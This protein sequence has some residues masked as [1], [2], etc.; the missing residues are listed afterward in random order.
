MS[1]KLK[2]CFD[3]VLG[4]IPVNKDLAKKIYDY[5]TWIIV[6]SKEMME[7]YGGNL[8][9]THR[10]WF[11]DSLITRLYD[12]FE[13]DEDL[14]TPHVRKVTTINHSFKV[15]AD[16]TN[17]MLMYWIHRFLEDTKLDEK[18]R[19]SAIYDLS[20]IFFY[21]C[22]CIIISDQFVF[23]ADPHV[24]RRTYEN[25]SGRYLIKKLGSWNKVI[26]YRAKALIDKKTSLHRKYLLT[27]KD[28]DKTVYAINDSQGRIKGT[29]KE[30]YA[31][32]VI[33]NQAG[34]AISSMGAV[35]EDMEGEDALRERRG[36][37][38]SVVAVVRAALPDK[39]SFI[40]DDLLSICSKIVSN[41]KIPTL[42]EVLEWM[43]EKSLEAN[44]FKDIDTVIT[45]TTIL[46]SFYIDNY[47]DPRQQRDLVHVLKTIKNHFL[48]S[49]SKDEDLLALRKSTD[50]IIG[51][52]LKTKLSSATLNS[53][54]LSV[55]L[56]VA[57]RGLVG[58]RNK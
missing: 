41:T 7:F 54:R 42:R 52:V 10:V 22:L 21:R 30:Y 47:I 16:V 11:K 6:S 49:K 56:Y 5:R 15:S 28:D 31:E 4:H 12:I 35:G 57:L 3:Q 14:L 55:I 24:A 44:Y 19:E 45:K 23:T 34:N 43:S 27:F 58:Y 9:G 1:F 37:A 53:V 48:S 25:L 36:G 2:Q 33:N 46:T 51:T 13:S 38:E 50:E 8:L 20:M 17:L 39:T 40:R 29:V 26:D 18:T 32:L